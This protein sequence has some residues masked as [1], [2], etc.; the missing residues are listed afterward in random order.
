M[1]TKRVKLRIRQNAMR[2]YRWSDRTCRKEDKAAIS[3]IR[4]K[5]LAS[6]D[7]KTAFILAAQLSIIAPTIPK[8]PPSNPLGWFANNAQ[9]QPLMPLRQGR[10][11]KVWPRYIHVTDSLVRECEAARRKAHEVVCAD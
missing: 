3:V 2:R 5:V 9:P 7:T 11:L 1:L 10:E 8:D 6:V 4:G